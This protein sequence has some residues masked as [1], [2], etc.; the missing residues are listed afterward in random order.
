MADGRKDNKGTKGNAGGRPPKAEEQKLIE[1]L[2]PLEPKAY[3]ALEDAIEDNQS[4]A[5]K[6]FFEYMYGRPKQAVDI[7]SGGEKMQQPI[8]SID[9]L[10]N[11]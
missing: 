10:E 4:W 8:I 1:K 6:I 5:V 2:S 9:P 11:D 7:T 3:Q